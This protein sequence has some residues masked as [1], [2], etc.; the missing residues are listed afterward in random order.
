MSGEKCVSGEHVNHLKRVC[1]S[2]TLYND[3]QDGEALD[4]RKCFCIVIY[5]LNVVPIL[6]LILTTLW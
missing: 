3:E 2:S 6:S 5:H 4:E 1:V